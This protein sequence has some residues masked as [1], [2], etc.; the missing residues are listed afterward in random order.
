[1]GIQQIARQKLEVIEESD[2]AIEHE[3]KSRLKQHY[4]Q[5]LS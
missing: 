3:K 5:L 1:M 4:S 2:K